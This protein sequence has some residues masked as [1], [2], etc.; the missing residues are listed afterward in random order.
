MGGNDSEDQRTTDIYMH[1]AATNSWK[2]ISH[3]KIPRQQCSVAVLPHNE[4]MV[5]GGRT[6]GGGTDSV[7]IAII[8]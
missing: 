5:V 4:L 6:P 3:L 2:V 8:V 1:N 7:E